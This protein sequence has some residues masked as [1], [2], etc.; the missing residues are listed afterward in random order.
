MTVGAGGATV[1]S[2]EDIPSYNLKSATILHKLVPN[3]IYD[4]VLSD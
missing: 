1:W 3:Q 4:P 2:N